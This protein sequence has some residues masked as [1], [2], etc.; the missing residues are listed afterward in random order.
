MALITSPS[1]V[2]A[3]TLS[4][5]LTAAPVVVVPCKT[6][7]VAGLV[8]TAAVGETVEERRGRGG[9]AAGLEGTR[10]GQD[11]GQRAGCLGTEIARQRDIGSRLA[12]N[13]GSHR[14]LDVIDARRL[15]GGTRGAGFAN[16]ADA[17]N[18]VAGRRIDQVAGG[19]DVEGAGAGVQILRAGV[20]D[21]KALALESDIERIAGG[22]QTPPD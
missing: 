10:G 11:L 16:R 4:V 17:L 1:V 15:E 2:V 5:V 6:S 8:G 22:G 13:A 20:G 3:S 9:S 21:E 7:G 14:N 18:F 19:V 12:R